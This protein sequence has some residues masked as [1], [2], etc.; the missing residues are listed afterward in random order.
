VS[1][2][3]L[4]LIKTGNKLA[5]KYQVILPLQFKYDFDAPVWRIRI[6][7]A[8]ARLALEVRD[9]DVL[10]A[11]FY[12]FDVRAYKLEQLELPQALTWWQGLEEAHNGRVYIHGY[13]DR[14]LGQH[15]GILALGAA[16]GKVQWEDTLLAFYGLAPEGILAYTAAAPGT[17]FLLLQEANG[18]QTGISISQERAAEMVTNYSGQRYRGCTYPM[19]YLEGEPYYEQVQDFLASQLGAIAVKAIEYAE[20]EAYMVVSYYTPAENAALDNFLAVFD[21]NGVLQLHQSL[22]QGLSGIG[23]DTF[24]IFEHDLYFLQ[25][26]QV[27]LV[28]R[29]LF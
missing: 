14:Q 28:Y 18:Q 20:T 19:L 21:L 6:D 11:Y 1:F 15:K 2:H 4:A 8:Q 17:D 16:T 29:L 5:I 3:K 23:S 24:F 7:T 25:N 27:L 22:G 13:A 9:A 10:L 12:T 26:K